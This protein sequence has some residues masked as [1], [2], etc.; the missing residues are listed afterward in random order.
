[1]AEAAARG[2]SAG[3]DPVQGVKAAFDRRQRPFEDKGGRRAEQAVA[4]DVKRARPKY[5]EYNFAPVSPP[6]RKAAGEGMRPPVPIEGPAARR[7]AGG[8]PAVLMPC[9]RRGA[10]R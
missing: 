4:H 8:T 10:G 6:L 9:H 5:S 2:G 1:M 7:F 3:E